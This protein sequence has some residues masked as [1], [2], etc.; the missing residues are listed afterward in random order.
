M[1]GQSQRKQSNKWG[2]TALTALS[3]IVF[4]CNDVPVDTANFPPRGTLEGSVVYSGPM[5]CVQRG[6][7]LG[8][9]LLLV[10]NEDLLPAPDGLGTTAAQFGVISGDILFES[11]AD[12]LPASSK[13][14]DEILCPPD[15]SPHV[16]VSAAWT[17]GPL[18]A[19]RYQIRGF[20]DRDGDFSPIMK[21]HQL[22]TA[23]DIGGG[24]IENLTEALQGKPVRYQTIELGVPSPQGK[25]RIP[26]NGTNV[27]NITV[28]LGQLLHF[29]RPIFHLA[30]VKD[31]RPTTFQD[32][33]GA[34]ISAPPLTPI[35]DPTQVVLP[36]DE[37]FLVA[38]TN[39]PAQASKMFLRV[40]LGAGLPG[41]YPQVEGE[42]PSERVLGANLP[43]SLQTL[44]PHDLFWIY[45]AV[46]AD[47]SILTVPETP[48]SSPP[49]TP[50]IASLFPQAIFAKL[51]SK[52][53]SKQT[54]QASPA[55]ILQGLVIHENLLSTT[56][57]NFR[58]T[59]TQEIKPPKPVQNLEVALR[60]SVICIPE[61]QNP[62]ATVYVVT[63]GF[64][65]I[66]GE[67]ILDPASIEAQVRAQLGNRPNIQVIEGCLPRGEYQMN[68]VYSTGQ[69]W[70]VPNE[71]GFC[72]YGEH[73]QENMC[74]FGT[75]QRQRLDS[76]AI[77]VAIGEARDTNFCEESFGSPEYIHGVPVVCLGQGER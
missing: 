41:A 20:Y 27:R 23:G 65:A 72:T 11:I 74:V 28:S 68:L 75:Q 4:S 3:T 42:A 16:T 5:P 14:S 47:G 22:P 67:S 6:H 54:A 2:L 12:Q 66:N 51:D 63:P 58:D 70:T 56:V 26:E 15:N 44:P 59:K 32:K 21:L 37:R 64:K 53:T 7:I 34:E 62:E 8:S 31:E 9:A 45:P 73:L 1:S 30:E 25:L 52:D 50:L 46:R 38:P 61:P 55:V 29:A 57:G 49:G 76:Q 19:G 24:A 48:S 39:Y 35:S 17:V 77:T 33:T 69:A 60:P 18:S 43:Y 10:F 71:A 36:Q 13:D 40:V